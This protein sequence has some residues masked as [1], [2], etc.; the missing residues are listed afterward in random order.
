MKIIVQLWTLVDSFSWQN[1]LPSNFLQECICIIESYHCFFFLAV[2]REKNTNKEQ[3]VYNGDGSSFYKIEAKM[4][5]VA[6]K[7]EK[8]WR[9]SSLVLCKVTKK[10]GIE[11]DA[12]AKDQ[13]NQ[14]FCIFQVQFQL[15]FAKF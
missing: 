6:A 1:Y 14:I 11:K 3:K 4:Q 8:M 9:F 5:K 13:F 10:I 15:N 12:E 2:R 7:F